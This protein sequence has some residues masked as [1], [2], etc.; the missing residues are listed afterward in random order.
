MKT[1]M[2]MATATALLLGT[3][4]PAWAHPKLVSSTPAA[5][6]TVA[7]A[8]RIA[9]TFS[10]RLMAP[11]SGAALVMTGM[12]GHAKHAPTKVSGFRTAM[13]PDGKTLS[14]TFAKPLS[15]GTYQL[16]WHAVAADTHRITGNLT[17]TVR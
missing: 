11:L 2:R 9:L 8:S 7:N 12:P 4:A 14:L 1:I 10:E 15:A 17:F 13:E 6:A 3:T 5:N 16:N